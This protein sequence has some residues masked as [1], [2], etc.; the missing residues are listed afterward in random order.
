[1]CE[2]AWNSPHSLPDRCLLWITPRI[3]SFT[4]RASPCQ[5]QSNEWPTWTWNYW[6]WSNKLSNEHQT[7][8]CN[9]NW[10]H[11]RTRL[12]LCWMKINRNVS[13]QMKEREEFRSHT[14]Q[15]HT[16]DLRKRKNRKNRLCVA[17]LSHSIWMAFA[18]FENSRY[19][20]IGVLVCKCVMHNVCTRENQ[21][22]MC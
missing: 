10:I 11:F 17:A 15:T 5:P 4:L 18:C 22:R 14:N 13:N 6:R 21:C 8:Y 19:G 3:F 2:I 7:L 20:S 16:V 1:M 12:E 9:I